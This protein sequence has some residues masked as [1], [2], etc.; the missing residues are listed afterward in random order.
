MRTNQKGFSAA[1]LAIIIVAVVVLGS[2]GFLVYRSHG[3]STQKV[4]T[5]TT[6][7]VS[8]GTDTATGTDADTTTSTSTAKD[9]IKNNDK[10]TSSNSSSHILYTSITPVSAVSDSTEN[11]G[12]LS[13]DAST[14]PLKQVADNWMPITEWGIKIPALAAADDTLRLPLNYE[15]DISAPDNSLVSVRVFQGPSSACSNGNR[16]PYVFVYRDHSWDDYNGA[17]KAADYSLIIS[18]HTYN[19]YKNT[20]S[21][22]C[23]GD[24]SLVVQNEATLVNQ[25]KQAL[26][27]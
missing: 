26:T 19:V 9:T 5:S 10:Q 7:D 6:K 1:E 24:S 20:S 12:Y 27:N 16:V 23:T 17:A 25:I 2:I 13:Y 8:K 4:N 14:V 21:Q 18:G 15:Y 22:G 3:D 11:T